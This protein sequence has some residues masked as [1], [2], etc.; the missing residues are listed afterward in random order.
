M[1]HIEMSPRI[2]KLYEH[3]YDRY[4]RD[5]I[6]ER[7]SVY[8]RIKESYA[9]ESAAMQHALAFSAFLGN[10]RVT[11][12]EYDLLAGHIQHVDFSASIPV[13]MEHDFD[14]A[15]RP[16]NRFDVKREE[17]QFFA[18]HP[19]EDTRSIRE[20]LDYFYQSTECGLG[21][22]WASGHVIA[23]Y[24]RV[25]R[26][27]LLAME[28]R[29]EKE[30]AGR[31]GEKKDYLGALLRVLH[32]A[33]NY[34]LRY[35]FAA[36][37]RSEETED[38]Q[39]QRTLR[40][41]GDACLHISRYPAESFFEAVQMIVL[42][43][44]MLTLETHS[45]S[46]SLGRIDQLLY[47]YY[48]QD[49]EKG[50][51]TKEEAA[52]YIDALW[53]KIAGLVYGFQNVT[54]GGCDEKGKPAYNDITI[55][56][57]QASRKIGKDQPLL[58]LRC[59]PDMPAAVWEE[60]LLLVKKGGGFPAFFNDDV[61]ISAKHSLGVKMQDAMNYGLVGC[62]EPSIGGKEFSNTEE[63]RINWA[64]V[65]EL[66]LH[67]GKCTVT[68]CRFAMARKE[69]L[70]DV[71]DFEE[72]FKWYLEELEFAVQR[73]IKA[74]NLLDRNYA[75]NWPCPFLSATVEGCIENAADVAA[76]GPVYRYSTINCCGMADTVDSLTVIRKAVFEEKLLKLSELS[77]M[78]SADFQGY[79]IWQKRFEIQ[80]PKYGNN[81][82]EA[83][84][85]MKK[86]VKAFERMVRGQKNEKGFSYQLGLYTVEDQGHLGK[87]TGALPSGRRKGVSLAN[88]VS[89]CQG[90]DV[91][92]PT[93]VINSVTEFS[94]R[95]AANGLVLDLKFTPTFLEKEKHTA[96][97]KELIGVYFE[98]GG[99]EVQF[100]VV[101]RQ[102]LLDAKEHPEQ[103]RNLVVRVSGFS[104]YFVLLDP[105]L[106]DEIIKRTEYGR[107]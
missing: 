65:L 61:I 20:L 52:E 73:C 101:D 10:K 30:M 27:G 36:Y 7:N 8:E 12:E 79:E 5:M 40:A 11:V 57:L 103:Y 28:R 99:M 22:R 63:L 94:H 17:E 41:I 56:C 92:G 59:R 66:M 102:T 45:G 82:L 104:A 62:V 55:L 86:L 64:K 97:L 19:N 71:K 49:L 74:T 58:S 60:A 54:I 76:E 85:Y 39:M 26:E 3:F 93:A 34:I 83:D 68:G 46:M 67:Q 77:A 9:D 32:G 18:D 31:Q 88:A 90:M 95:C 43:H 69:E 80:Y 47:P 100:N 53:L 78:L 42:L 2:S 105:V 4:D 50:K 13:I 14:P 29:I 15:G 81:L 23:G 51:L 38:S 44:E 84:V 70:D 98:K 72:F 25:I 87:F 1:N 6:S 48:V 106:Q 24:N 16:A 89:P 35:A 91:E 75:K 21:K 33:E 107:F 37:R 96:M